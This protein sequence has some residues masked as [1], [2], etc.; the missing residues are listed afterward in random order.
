MAIKIKPPYGVV[1]RRG[2]PLARGLAGAW[3]FNEG[4]GDKVWDLSGSDYIGTLTNMTSS[5]DWVSGPHGHALDFDGTD[6]RVIV[7][8]DAGI[9]LSTAN[10]C[11]IRF[12]ARAS[13]TQVLFGHNSG[14]DGGYFLSM[15]AQGRTHYC[16]SGHEVYMTHGVLTGDEVWLAVSRQGTSVQHYK[17]GLPLGTLLTLNANSVLKVSSIGAYRQSP[18]Y[19]TNMRCDY[20]YCWRRALSASEMAWLY[21]EPFCFVR[22]ELALPLVVLPGGT[23]HET[24]G[25]AAAASSAGAGAAMT[26]AGDLPTGRSWPQVTLDVDASW[27]RE[28]ILNG[29]TDAGMKLGT[30]LTQG[31]F[32][33]RRNGC[34]AVYRVEDSNVEF[35][36]SHFAFGS[37]AC[38]APLDADQV[39]L[40]AYLPHEPGSVRAYLLRRFGSCGYQDHT[41]DAQVDVRIGSDGQL[42]APAPNPVFGLKAVSRCVET[43]D[44][45]FLH[46]FYCPLDQKAASYVFRI[47]G[48]NGMDEIDFVHPLGSLPYAGRKFYRWQSQS[49][50]RGKYLFAVRAES[51]CGAEGPPSK[52][53]I[54]IAELG[55]AE[56]PGIPDAEAI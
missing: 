35:P 1:L 49:L 48:N 3:V 42:A 36:D 54:R 34:S 2:H 33:T 28:A 11:V 50:E 43:Q 4:T 26:C 22:R 31:W 10:A 24:G 52:V 20:V 44:V 17:D 5:S 21:R 41:T 19:P 37:P 53:E 14:T 47:Y 23:I 46:W 18:A 25:S 13:T 40:P 45:A 9:D 32:W 55:S 12:K 29:M 30:V 8:P 15:E 6:D 7:G 56:R 27:L 38:V 16:A 51:T 39:S